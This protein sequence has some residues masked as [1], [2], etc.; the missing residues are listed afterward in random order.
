M[1]KYHPDRVCRFSVSYH[2]YL[3]V[4]DSVTCRGF[5]LSNYSQIPSDIQP[6]QTELELSF[7]IFTSSKLV[8]SVVFLRAFCSD[9]H[10]VFCLVGEF[11]HMNHMLS[12]F[13]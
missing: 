8:N 10:Q 4:T 1:G 3:S 12:G 11:I 7:R 13:S 5:K 6:F 2:C 9:V